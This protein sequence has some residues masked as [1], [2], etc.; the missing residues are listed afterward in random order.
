MDEVIHKQKSKITTLK[1][2]EK[3]KERIDHLRSYRRESYDEILQK[4]LQV[5]NLCRANPA[6][7]QARLILIDKE[8]KRNLSKSGN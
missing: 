6:R 4:I 8:K 2:A 5:L 1:V 3:T 7:A